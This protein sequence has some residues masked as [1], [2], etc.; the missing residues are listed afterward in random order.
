[1]HMLT[2]GVSILKNMPLP[3]QWQAIGISTLAEDIFV[4]LGKIEN[5]RYKEHAKNTNEFICTYDWDLEKVPIKSQGKKIKKV[6]V[7]NNREGRKITL[8]TLGKIF[9]ANNILEIILENLQN[10]CIEISFDPEN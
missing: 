8:P 4:N 2:L 10:F 3:S 5:S 9:Y 6:D 7:I 1:M